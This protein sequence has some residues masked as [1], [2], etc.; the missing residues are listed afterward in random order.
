MSTY[1]E[2]VRA[3]GWEAR[4]ELGFHIQGQPIFHFRGAETRFFFEAAIGGALNVWARPVRSGRWPLHTT[5]HMPYALSTFLGMHAASRGVPPEPLET[6]RIWTRRQLFVALEFAGE[7]FLG[8]GSVILYVVFSWIR[9]LAN[10]C[11]PPPVTAILHVP[12]G[13]VLARWVSEGSEKNVWR[14][15]ASFYVS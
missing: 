11:T 2:R 13:A 1:W 10:W 15:V 3:L 9:V 14:C 5:Y 7:M 6:A 8:P 4:P 12:R